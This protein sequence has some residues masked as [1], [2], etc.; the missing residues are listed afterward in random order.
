MSWIDLRRRRSRTASGDLAM[1]FGVPL[2]GAYLEFYAD[3]PRQDHPLPKALDDPAA[4][5]LVR[6]AQ[7]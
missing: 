6:A 2:L 4:A 3:L 5:S 7:T 1:S